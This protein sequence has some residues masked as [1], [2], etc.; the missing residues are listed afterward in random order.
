VRLLQRWRSRTLRIFLDSAY[1]VCSPK[2]THQAGLNGPF[3][4]RQQRVFG[5]R[6]TPLRARR[7]RSRR[8]RCP[9]ARGSPRK[10]RGLRFFG[11][12]DGEPTRTPSA[13]MISLVPF[14]PCAKSC[15]Q[16]G[17]ATLRHYEAPRYCVE[18]KRS[19]PSA[20]GVRG[21]VI[22]FLMRSASWRT[23]AEFKAAIE[24]SHGAP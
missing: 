18:N 4:A 16:Y 21:A 20:S 13:W 14:L 6:Q 10:V 5:A 2:V 7:R 22:R 23:S 9:A 1:I 17:S 3:G 8:S 24:I 15:S 12:D 19:C 11:A